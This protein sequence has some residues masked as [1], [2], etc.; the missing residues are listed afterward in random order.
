MTQPKFQILEMR[1]SSPQEWLSWWA[2]RYDEETDDDREYHEIIRGHHS[3]SA[4]DFVRLG[5]WKDGVTTEA[6]W[7]PNVAKVAFPIWTEAAERLPKCPEEGSA[8]SFLEEW[9]GKAY[10]DVY[11]NGPRTKRFGMSRATTLLHFLSG[12]RYPIYDSRVRT[13]IARLL[14]QPALPDEVSA[15]AERFLPIF[16][17][18]ANSCKTDDLRMLDK[19]LFA[20]GALDERTYLATNPRAHATGL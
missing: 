20:Y 14:H 19:A 10:T 12:G 11:K 2:K 3:F 1:D 18:L 8:L 4:Q 6:Q 17:E 5:K 7:K 9:S 13:A 15:Y 16:S